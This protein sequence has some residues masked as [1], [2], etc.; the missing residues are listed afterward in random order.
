MAQAVSSLSVGQHSAV[1]SITLGTPQTL[2]HGEKLV[3]NIIV[4]KSLLWRGIEPLIVGDKTE[5]GTLG[6]EEPKYK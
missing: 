4:G 5:I 1:S 3:F 2:R 6:F